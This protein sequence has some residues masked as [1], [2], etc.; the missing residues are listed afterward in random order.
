MTPVYLV[1]YTLKGCINATADMVRDHER[2]PGWLTMNLYLYLGLAFFFGPWIVAAR[3]ARS[4]W[5]SA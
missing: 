5:P 3:I 2:C 1:N 4:G